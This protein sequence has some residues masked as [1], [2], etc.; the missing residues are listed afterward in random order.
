MVTGNFQIKEIGNCL[1]PVKLDFNHTVAICENRI[2][3]D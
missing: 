3:I 1:I 2:P